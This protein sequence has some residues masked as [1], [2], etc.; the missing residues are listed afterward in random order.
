MTLSDLQTLVTTWVDDPNNG[1][2]SLA[3]IT[4]FLNNSQREVQKQLLQCGELWYAQPVQTVTVFSQNIYPLPPD[5]LQLHRCEIVLSGTPPNESIITLEPFTLNEQ[6]L[7]PT[8][9]GTPIGSSILQNNLYIY[10]APDTGNLNFR[11][12]YSP[13]VVDMVNPTDIP[14]VPTQF[15]EYI[16]ILATLDCFLKDQRDPAPFIS[17]RDFYLTLLKEMADRRALSAP[18]HVVRTRIDDY[19]SLF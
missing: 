5:F 1:Y 11:I 16:A 9:I 18:R 7:A 3:Q 6:D 19:G 14:N 15:Q 17:K 13:L 10:P 2:F 4:V 8:G 12:Y